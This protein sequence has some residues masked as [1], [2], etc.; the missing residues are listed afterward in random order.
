MRKRIRGLA[1]PHGGGRTGADSSRRGS[2]R[3]DAKYPVVAGLFNGKL[4][5]RSETTP[6]ALNYLRAI[7]L[8]QRL[9]TVG[10]PQVHDDDIG[11]ALHRLQAGLK[12]AGGIQGNDD[13]R[14]RQALGH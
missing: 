4:L 10:T 14:N 11:A 2:L 6:F 13:G 1:S 8:R 5:L 7:A 3:H 12:L 9:G